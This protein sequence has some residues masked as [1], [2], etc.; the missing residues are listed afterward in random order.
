MIDPLTSLAF[1][2]QENKG[3]FALLLGSGV[4]RAAS[5]PTGWEIT[6]DLTRRV[7]GAQGVDEQADWAEWYR[8]TYSSEPDYS[9]LLDTLGGTADERRAI[10][11]AYIEPSDDDRAADLKQP[12]KAHRAIAELVRSVHVRLIL[13]TNFDRLLENALRDVGIEPSIIA[14]KDD[15]A[16]AVPL[17]HSSCTIVKLHGDYLDTRILNTPSELETYSAEMDI[18]LDRV[19]DEH[20]LIISGW[21][22]DWDAALRRAILRAPN[23]RYSTFW[24]SRSAPGVKAQELIT[25]RAAK[26]ITVGDAD[27]L[28][29]KLQEQVTSLERMK[30]PNPLT[31]DL[32]VA[33]AKRFAARPEHRIDLHDLVS[34]EA[35]AL[36]KILRLPEYQLSNRAGDQHLRDLVDRYEVAC[37]R[38]VR[39][40]A[41]TTR[42]SVEGPA[43]ARNCIL[44]LEADE[45][46]P[47]GGVSRHILQSYPGLLTFYV[48]GMVA[49][50]S[51]D[52]KFL[53]SLFDIKVK[54]AF[55][56]PKSV[57]SLYPPFTSDTTQTEFWQT[58][59]GKPRYTPM[60]D[61]LAVK[62]PPFLKDTS[63]E[64]ADVEEQFDEFELV[65]GLASSF[66]KYGASVDGHFW[67]PVGRLSWKHDER[68]KAIA[69]IKD[70]GLNWAPFEAG[71]FATDY[72][73]FERFF[74]RAEAWIERMAGSRW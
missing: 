26:A 67:M 36:R 35:S 18:F 71:I 13:T 39:V 5:I 59:A 2:V 40:L 12:T 29:G 1:T 15:L 60:S 37:E 43:L 19:L 62:L 70:A 45:V 23:R 8:K 32:A 21:S 17:I 68:K 47:S 61:H 6:L 72:A 69:K 31:V 38:L 7:A 52:E 74:A 50:R 33:S 66:Q 27:T 55:G 44:A 63:I 51:G 65:A 22:G 34:T 9:I 54:R 14:S 56:E 24:A 10:L 28:F 46:S 11:H 53:K 49:Y 20:G 73:Q 57:L 48:V 3:V 25:K 4:S 16:G 42:W 58:I 30:R 41:V 64:L